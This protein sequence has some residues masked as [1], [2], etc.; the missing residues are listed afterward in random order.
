MSPA[1][2]GTWVIA[3]VAAYLLAT[4]VAWAPLEAARAR[5]QRA[6]AMLLGVGVL[7]F[8]AAVTLR[9][10][11]YQQ[12]PFMTLYETVLSNLL[13]LGIVAFAAIAVSTEARRGTPIVLVVLA[14]LGAWAL[15]LPREAVPLPPS[16]ES[17]WLWAHVL[18]GKIFL[19][20]SL[21]AVGIATALLLGRAGVPPFIASGDDERRHDASVWRFL[22]AAFVFHSAMLVVGAVWAHDAWGRFWAWDPLETWSFV[23]WIALGATLHLRVTVRLRLPVGWAMALGVFVLAFLTFFGVPFLSLAPHKGVF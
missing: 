2:E 3:A 13:T 1:P 23:T 16:F 12:G 11:H 5:A 22:S 8:A 10:Q 7:L 18:C 6:A 9:W 15:S 4:L 17:P 14:V 19:G 21:V 20:T